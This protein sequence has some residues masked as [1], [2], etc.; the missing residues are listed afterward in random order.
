MI[1]QITG[2]REW[3]HR[4]YLF[5]ILDD[6]HA[7]YGISGIRCGCARGADRAA[8][9]P[10]PAIE[11]AWP[12]KA[13]QPPVGWAAS[14]GVPVGHYPADWNRLSKA[15]GPIR[16]RQMLRG[17]HD[18]CTTC[19][20]SGGGLCDCVAN[21]PDQVLAFHT[22]FM[23]SKGTKDMVTIARAV[24]IPAFIFPNHDIPLDFDFEPHVLKF[25]EPIV[26]TGNAPNAED[27]KLR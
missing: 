10:C 12:Q 22:N 4:E 15:A 11:R 5:N 2:D 14:R 21:F 1:V 20:Y 3:K 26:H 19:G 9:W 6:F 18:P 8:G 24:K 16:N 25:D 7:L 27:A 17:Q 13:P 23:A